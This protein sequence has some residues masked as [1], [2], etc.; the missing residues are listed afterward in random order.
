MKQVRDD[1]NQADFADQESRC[2]QVEIRI[3]DLL[4]A[5]HSL[6]SDA[7]V[8]S[9]IADCDQCAQLV[10]DFGALEDSLS[11]IPLSTIRRLSGI[12]DGGGAVKAGIQNPDRNRSHSLHPIAFIASVASLVLVMLTSSLWRSADSVPDDSFAAVVTQES[13]SLDPGQFEF[14]FDTDQDLLA[15]QF[16]STETLGHLAAQVEPFSDPTVQNCLLL[17]TDL[18]GIR[19]VKHSVN[20]TLNLIRGSSRNDSTKPVDQKKSD[21]SDGAGIRRVALRELAL[22]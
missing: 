18:P 1:K 12:K 13:Q 5:R 22:A 9:H 2:Q 8:R 11:Q 15:A 19:Q 14:M 17:T 21:S 20:A 10:V 6:L 3:N 16:I 7:V 4:D